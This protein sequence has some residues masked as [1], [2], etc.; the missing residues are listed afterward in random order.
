MPATTVGCLLDKVLDLETHIAAFYAK[1]RDHAENNDVRLLAYYLSRRRRRIA[2]VIDSFASGVV[3]E[4]RS[5][6]LEAPDRDPFT[7][8]HILGTPP[9]D[10]EGKEL[11]SAAEKH[12]FCLLELYDIIMGHAPIAAEA[13][14]MFK[15]LIEI[16]QK[17]VKMLKKMKAMHYF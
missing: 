5:A 6:G 16:E 11:L 12:C 13:K 4:I 9:N 15:S 10:V 14:K 2:E 8:F 17:D 1:L 7:C 3:E